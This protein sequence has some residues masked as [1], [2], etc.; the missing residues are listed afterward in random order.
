[1][2]EFP[3]RRPNGFVAGVNMAFHRHTPKPVDLATF[4]AFG[5]PLQAG[6]AN[7][8]V[9]TP[10]ARCRTKISVVFSADVGGAAPAVADPMLAS[11]P[12][13]NTLWLV[14]RELSGS[15]TRTPV[16]NLA[17]TRAAPLAIPTDAGLWGYEDQ[18]ETAGDE[19]FGKLHLV[20]LGYI[21]RVQLRVRYAAMEPMSQA[22]WSNLVD[23]AIPWGGP[24]LQMAAL[25]D[26]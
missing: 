26:G 14:Y 20:P 9:P 21:G 24:V 19:V 25:L 12:A 5:G 10:D 7:F 23:K 6:D 2:N 8:V 11:L 1:M 4:H 3:D 13:G 16:R 18:I 22:E 17:G 15:G